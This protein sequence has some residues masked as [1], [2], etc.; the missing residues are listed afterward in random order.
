MQK[1]VGGHLADRGCLRAAGAL[2]WGVAQAQLTLFGHEEPSFDASFANLR[3]VELDAD[4]FVG[5]LVGHAALFDHLLHTTRWRTG[6]ER[7]YDRTLPTPRLFAGLPADGP[8]HPV[9]DAMQDALSHHYGEAFVRMSLALYRD[10][11]DSVAHHGD[12]VA[13]RLPAALVATVSVGAPRRF[14]LRP[15]AGGASVG[16]NLGWGDLLVMGGSC[17]RTWQH[18]IPKVARADARIA[19][20]HRPAW[21]DPGRT[22][23]EIERTESEVDD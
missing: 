3:R 12:R 1:N 23:P 7:I 2:R 17:Q 11:R 22:E 21:F 8:G 14:L 19:I 18:G 9:L 10:G 6:E 16:F 13:R 4:A 5:W 15:R 20:M